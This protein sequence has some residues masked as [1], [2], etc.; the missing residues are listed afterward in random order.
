MISKNKYAAVSA[1]EGWL[2]TPLL[3]VDQ[4]NRA[5]ADA[6]A[7]ATG[8][9]IVVA[10]CGV[11]CMTWSFRLVLA[12][13]LSLIFSVFYFLC[14]FVGIGNRHIGILE[15]LGFVIFFSYIATP[16]LRVVQ[17]YAY[18]C[19]GP[20]P[21][22]GDHKCE[23]NSCYA[24]D[25]VGI[26][27]GAARS[28]VSLWPG[29]IHEERRRRMI[30]AIQRA[31]ESVI[32]GSIAC[33]SVGATT[34]CFTQ[35]RS[36]DRV[37][38][39]LLC[40]A[41]TVLPFA[42]GLLPVLLLRGLGPSKVS[43]KASLVVVQSALKYRRAHLRGEDDLKNDEVFDGACKVLGRNPVRYIASCIRRKSTESPPQ[44]EGDTVLPDGDEEDAEIS[45][46][47]ATNA[48]GVGEFCL[49]I[50]DIQGATAMPPHHI[51]ITTTGCMKVDG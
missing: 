48:D 6:F 26:T 29:A 12:V 22:C 41:F 46:A 23:Q 38:L 9:M 19:E 42:F 27:N 45:E 8:V 35:L 14:I 33:M 13:I 30:T 40:G 51:V 31:G 47:D 20:G 43:L 11:F 37:G 7:L 10:A 25:R 17:Q 2:I 1:G 3:V 44:S 39:M 15:M 4:Q 32:G 50:L 28:H 24:D 21:R 5:V 18:S 16:L 36:I 49:N 34:T